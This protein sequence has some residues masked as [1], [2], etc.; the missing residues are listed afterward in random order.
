MGRELF[1]TPDEEVSAE[2]NRVCQLFQLALGKPSDR[3][4]FDS[5]MS[6]ANANGLNWIQGLEYVIR[7]RPSEEA[8]R[9]RLAVP[10]KRP[11][12]AVHGQDTHPLSKAS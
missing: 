7:H 2:F 3:V 9:S 8:E 6:E 10:A 4:L 12:A 11:A 5:L 1:R